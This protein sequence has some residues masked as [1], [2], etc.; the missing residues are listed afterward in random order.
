MV[1]FVVS[2]LVGVVVRIC[3]GGAL[4]SSNRTK[5]RGHGQSGNN[6]TMGKAATRRRGNRNGLQIGNPSSVLLGGNRNGGTEE[7]KKRP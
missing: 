1:T 2:I 3:G 7:K 5:R 6:W 4:C